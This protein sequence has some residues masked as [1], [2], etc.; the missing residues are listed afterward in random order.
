LLHIERVILSNAKDPSAA[1]S[2]AR[3]QA[4]GQQS[5]LVYDLAQSTDR[6]I[7]LALRKQ[8][9]IIAFSRAPYTARAE[10]SGGA[11]CRTAALQT[12]TTATA[13]RKAFFQDENSIRNCCT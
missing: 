4:F 3:P 6:G 1:Q 7:G 2:S 11:A 5:I 9:G 12:R 13:A 10:R 8:E